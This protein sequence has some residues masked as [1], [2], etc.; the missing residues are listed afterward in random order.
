[1]EGIVDGETVCS[2]M[3]QNESDKLIVV[4]T[5]LAGDLGGRGEYA[6][7]LGSPLAVR[8]FAEGG[9]EIRLTMSLCSI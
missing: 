8:A 6:G 1:M 5:E 7:S 3:S 2:Q 4:G 9:G